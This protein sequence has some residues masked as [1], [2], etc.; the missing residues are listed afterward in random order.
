MDEFANVINS[1]SEFFAT[2][3]G[4]VQKGIDTFVDVQNQMLGPNSKYSKALLGLGYTASEVADGLL[5]IM[6]S[7]VVMNKSD[8]ANNDRLMSAT[9]V[10]LTELDTLSKITGKRKDQIAKEVEAAENDQIWKTF[11]E[12]ITDPG[13]QA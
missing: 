6:K 10:Y 13:Q 8:L 2:M 3:G 9:S 12:N 1:N 7:G 5:G 11:M 4:N